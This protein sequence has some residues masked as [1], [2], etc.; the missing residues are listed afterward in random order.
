MSALGKA[1]P[2]P[3]EVLAVGEMP[4]CQD[5]RVARVGGRRAAR[6][7]LRAGD[8]ELRCERAAM[9]GAGFW[10]SSQWKSPRGIVLSA[11]GP[12]RRSAS[13]KPSASA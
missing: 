9:F 11:R 8:D 1:L 3:A 10:A 13:E 6:L 4:V 12:N 7:D 5:D 2:E